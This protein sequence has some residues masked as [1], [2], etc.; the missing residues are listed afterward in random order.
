VTSPTSLGAHRVTTGA[1]GPYGS[2]CIPGEA[3][4]L[5]GRRH[6]VQQHEVVA[7]RAAREE[8][9]QAPLP[10]R[11]TQVEVVDGLGPVPDLPHPA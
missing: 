4:H 5:D 8:R 9:L 6:D 7:V 2:G 1:R 10:Q 3:H 11:A